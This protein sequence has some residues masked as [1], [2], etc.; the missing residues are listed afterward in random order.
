MKRVDIKIGFACNNHCRFCVQ[1]KKRYMKSDKDNLAIKKILEDARRDCDGVVFT[2]GEPTIRSDI[3]DLVS[4]AKK[5][6]FKTIQIQTNGRIFYYKKFC[7]EIIA[8]GANEFSPALHGH[9]AKVHDYLT[10]SA[11]SFQETLTGIINLKQRNQI[12]ITNTVITK[13]N[14]RHLPQIAELLVKLGVDQFQFAFVHAAGSAGD[15]FYSVVPRIS[16]VMPYV[17]EGLDIGIKANKRVMTEAIPYCFMQGYEDCIAEKI[18]PETRIYDLGNVIDNFTRVRK[19]EGK[20]K[21][22]SC[23]RCGHLKICE[24][25][26]KEYPEKFGWSEFIPV[27]KKYGR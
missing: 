7:D 25:P 21:G 6:K 20:T 18:I 3:L 19:K 22:L 24:G 12:V 16:M 5:L 23:R 26:W 9:I 14:Y 11:G 10:S 2:G 17:K 27:S 13:S 4:Y 8:A 1:G 15:N